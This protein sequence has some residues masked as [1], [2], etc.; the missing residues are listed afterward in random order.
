MNYFKYFR[1][2]LNELSNY[3][4]LLLYICFLI[5]SLIPLIIYL[6]IYLE[7]FPEM[8]NSDNHLILK[9]LH[10]DYGSLLNNLYENGQYVQKIGTFEINFHLARMPFYPFFFSFSF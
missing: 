8:I 7:K 1:F 3:H 4:L 9:S 6:S 5:I 2:N 10:F